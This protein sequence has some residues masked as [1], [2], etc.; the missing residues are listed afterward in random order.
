MVSRGTQ[1]VGGGG[2]GGGTCRRVAPP[3]GREGVCVSGGGS[4]RSCLTGVRRGAAA[5]RGR[6]PSLLPSRRG[7]RRG[8]SSSLKKIC[9]CFVSHCFVIVAFFLFFKTLA[10]SRCKNLLPPAISVSQ[11]SRLE[12][13]RVI[14]NPANAR[15]MQQSWLACLKRRRVCWGGE[16]RRFT[17][18]Y[19]KKRKIPDG[20]TRGTVPGPQCVSP[21]EV[22]RTELKSRS[23]VR[24]FKPLLFTVHVAVC[25]RVACHRRCFSV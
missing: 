5:V 15:I 24:R 2:R 6:L 4:V 20:L 12:S 1:F 8:Y 21:L 11:L 10:C 13:P 25:A 3:R 9:Y 23:P 18:R 7:V 16:W 17:S 22:S 14:L 19:P